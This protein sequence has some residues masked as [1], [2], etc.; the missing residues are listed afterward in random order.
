MTLLS[1]HSSVTALAITVV[2]VMVSSV[3]AF[4]PQMPIVG[5]RSVSD[6][7]QLA[8]NFAGRR[9]FDSRLHMA[10]H[11]STGAVATMTNSGDGGRKSSIQLKGSP[12]KRQMPTYDRSGPVVAIHSIGDFL[13]EIENTK[14]N[15]LVIV[16]FHAKFCK[17]CARVILKYKKMAMQHR[18]K[19]TPV[20]IKFLSIESTENMKIIRTL[21]VK[22]FPF[23]QIYR[24]RECVASFGTGGSH[25]FQRA[26]G[27]TV[28]QKLNSSE[29]EWDAFSSEFKTEISEGLE[30]LELLRLQSVLDNEHAGE[31]FDS[32]SNVGP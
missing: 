22:K 15:E 26:V 31:D 1:I 25:N 28:E 16:K 27:G 30:Q 24:N 5:L 21:G 9:M 13:H 10:V 7:Q 12:K 29:E 32:S 6:G 3:S 8:G 14:P 11:N 2:F 23:L 4:S 18:D 17:V 19:E 20:P